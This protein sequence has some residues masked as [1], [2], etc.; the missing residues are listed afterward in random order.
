MGISWNEMNAKQKKLSFLLLQSFLSG[1]AYQQ[2][3]DIIKLEN[4]LKQMEPHRES[5]VRDPGNYKFVFF[6]NPLKEKAY[7]WRFEGH[8]LSFT[9]SSINHTITSATPAFMGSNPA[10]ILTGSDK[11]KEILKDESGLGFHYYTHSSQISY[12]KLFYQ[13][14]FHLTS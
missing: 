2:S 4:I 7:V 8:H 13:G 14:R 5:W 6:G 10:I 1:K 9:F 11:G 12:L 3:Q